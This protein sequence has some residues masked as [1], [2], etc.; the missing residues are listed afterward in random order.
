MKNNDGQL[1]FETQD[2]LHETPLLI[3]ARAGIANVETINIL[4]D[5][6]GMLPKFALLTYL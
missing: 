5:C 4:I 1:E 6:G 3:S 2:E